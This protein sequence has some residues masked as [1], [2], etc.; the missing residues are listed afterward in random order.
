MCIDRSKYAPL[1]F[2][3]PCGR[4]PGHRLN[5]HKRSVLRVLRVLRGRY[6]PATQANVISTSMKCMQEEII[7]FVCLDSGTFMCVFPP[8]VSDPVRIWVNTR[9]LS[10]TFLS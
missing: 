7:A 9:L 2:D 10:I 3:S 5:A 4:P 8:D 1:S 6:Q